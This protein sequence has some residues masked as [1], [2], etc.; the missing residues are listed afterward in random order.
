M[1]TGIAP[2]NRPRAGFCLPTHRNPS[3][4]PEPLG[5]EIRR[6]VGTAS[7]LGF[8][9]VWVWDHL[10]PAA[11]LYHYAWHEPMACLAAAAV[12][13][14]MQ[15]GT[16]ILIAPTHHPVLIAQSVSTLQELSGKQMLLGLG[17]GWNRPE[18]VA[19][20]QRHEDRG[21]VLDEFIDVLELLF[22]GGGSYEG[23]FFPFED[24]HPGDLGS[25]PEIWIAGGAMLQ[26]DQ[27]PEK[28]RIAPA[29]ARRIRRAGNWLIRTTTNP[30]LVRQDLA[31][32]ARD[33]GAP[34]SDSDVVPKMAQINVL[35]LVESDDPA[36]ARAVQL[37]A[38]YHMMSEHRGMDY[39]DKTYLTGS[40]PEV[41]AK[42]E[43]WCELGLEHLV[44]YP[45]KDAPGQLELWKKHLSD[46]LQFRN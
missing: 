43:A 18:F 11:P 27:S 24:V 9:S 42:I 41:R 34:E 46:L 15:L 23:R 12:T 38:F 45:P 40:L 35:Y 14:D 21:K 3:A 2:N 6:T 30:A 7:Q 44:L 29:V 37:D 26:H 25:A 31:T 17:T 10:L 13:G 8:S 33:A 28:P 16:G 32:L 20:Q 4:H 5:E 36:E 1:S 39:F 22:A 19:T